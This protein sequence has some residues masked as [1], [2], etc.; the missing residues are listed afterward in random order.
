MP[1]EAGQHTNV[2][3][4]SG[5]FGDG[6][7]FTTDNDSANYFGGNRPSVHIQKY[8][9]TNDGVTWLD[10]DAA[11][12]PQAILGESVSFRFEVENDGNVPLTA[13]S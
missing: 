8:V 9:S 6:A 5:A 10:A 11:P 1:V 2:A 3:T 12:G 13:I 4:A 7:G